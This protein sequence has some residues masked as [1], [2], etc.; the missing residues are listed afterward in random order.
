MSSV[1]FLVYFLVTIYTCVFQKSYCSNIAILCNP[2]PPLAATA[3]GC[4]KNMI[5]RS[6]PFAFCPFFGAHSFVFVAVNVSHEK[7][8]QTTSQGS[9]ELC[10][11]LITGAGRGRV[12][13]DG[14]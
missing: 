7:G 12:K 5:I 4:I 1:A 11:E 10:C 3:P 14:N 6:I 2:H 8:I 9:M 13:I